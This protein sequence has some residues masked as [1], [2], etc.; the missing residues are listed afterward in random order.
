[1][2]PGCEIKSVLAPIST[3]ARVDG[4]HGAGGTYLNPN[5]S[6]LPATVSFE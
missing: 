5:T 6:Q 1:M 2:E 3:Y 4:A